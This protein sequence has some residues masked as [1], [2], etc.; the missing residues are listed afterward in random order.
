[1]TQIYK[2]FA[3]D[4]DKVEEA[5]SWVQD[6]LNA[7]KMERRNIQRIRLTAEELLLNILS[8]CGSG[9]QVSIGLGKQFGRQMLR[10]RYQG[11]AF[12]PVKNS[13]YPLSDEIMRSLGVLPSWSYR[14]QMNTVS[15]T[16]SERPKR[17]S[18]FYI[19]LAVTAAVVLGFA[20]RLFPVALRQSTT[21]I[22]L[23]P[24][25]NGFL[26]LMKTFSG[27]LIMLTICSGILGMGD[28]AT[29][30]QRGR[31]F[32]SRY[33]GISFIL[34]AAV[35][36]VALPLLHIDPG[37]YFQPGESSGFAQISQLIFGILPSDPVEPF[38]TGN[39][40]QLIV[41]ALL[42]GA[43]LLAIGER[44]KSLRSLVEE[45]TALLQRMVSGI[46]ALVPLY[47]FAMLLRQIWFGEAGALLSVWKLMVLALS[48][49]VI[50]SA[51][52]LLVASLR[53]KINPLKMLKKILP[54]TL[55][56][57][58]TA[59]SLAALTLSLETCERK[60]G[61]KKSTVTFAY[62]LGSVIFKPGCLFSF[63]VFVCFFVQ[64]YH[65]AVNPAWCLLT[66]I[67]VTLL[68]IAFP[69]IPGGGVLV[70]TIM[71]STLGIP[72]EALIMVTAVE[73]VSEFFATGSNIMLLLLEIACGA[74]RLGDLDRTVLAEN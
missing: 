41:I 52:Y 1:M 59:S 42:I 24:L 8:H 54:P 30:G 19:L 66:L 74:A 65:V 39:T 60:L 64:F 5:S 28:S 61:I 22:L 2:E 3:L 73:I 70:F 58:T 57:F 14:G 6:Y 69:P 16:L 18:V 40:L 32:A 35:M 53:L 13:E 11:E 9:V 21:D 51:A 25:A 27:I 47:V 29:L 7:Q 10:L 33:I 34:C 15:M 38:R 56:A 44:G 45:S 71:F 68:V 23:M 62:P 17:G 63:T 26:G 72:T 55:I 46:C 20:G 48:A 43:G 12:D 49:E 50:F 4:A 31:H 36:A 67:T 37:A